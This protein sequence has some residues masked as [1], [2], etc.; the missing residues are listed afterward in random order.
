MAEVEHFVVDGIR[1]V[2]H[3]S[4]CVCND[5]IHANEEVLRLLEGWVV[6]GSLKGLLGLR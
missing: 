4:S 2:K 6:L 5:L 1:F 3:W